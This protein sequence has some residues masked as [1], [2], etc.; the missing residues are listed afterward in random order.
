M[1]CLPTVTAP[2]PKRIEQ[3]LSSLVHTFTPGGPLPPHNAANGAPNY[4]SQLSFNA[5]VTPDQRHLASLA[6]IFNIECGSDTML[7]IF[8]PRDDGWREVIRWQSAPY[9]EVSG[10]FWNFIY[11]ISSPDADGSS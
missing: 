9:Q 1:A 5:R 10:A 3:A 7:L 6:I 2:G 4:G 8:A 11:V